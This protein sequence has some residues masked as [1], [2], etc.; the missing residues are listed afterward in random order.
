MSRG[1]LRRLLD[2]I[3]PKFGRGWQAGGDALMT[4]QFKQHELSQGTVKP[5]ANFKNAVLW[6]RRK[7]GRSYPALARSL[8]RFQ[9]WG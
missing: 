9:R 4:R 6:L 8:A 7:G 5:A 2:G 1:Q 3:Q